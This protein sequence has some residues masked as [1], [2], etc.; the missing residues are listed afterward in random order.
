MQ[1]YEAPT[2]CVCQFV[3]HEIILASTSEN[4]EEKPNLGD[5]TGGKTQWYDIWS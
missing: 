1:K 4:P 2:L 5:V 3:L